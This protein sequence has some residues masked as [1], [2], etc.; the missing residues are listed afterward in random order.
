MAE[1]QYQ[2]SQAYNQNMPS[3][4]SVSPNTG[5]VNYFKIL[6]DLCGI[7]SSIGLKVTLS[8]TPGAQGS[9]G[10]TKDWGIEIPYTI[11][12]K[13]LT[14]QGKTFV[15]D[16]GWTSK[17]GYQ[18]RLKYVNNHVMLFESIFPAQPLPSRHTDPS[19]QV[20]TYCWRFGAIDG[21]I[22]YFGK[23]LEHVDI[24]GNS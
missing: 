24:Y 21:A 6:I 13:S 12:G 2:G 8:Y 11:P 17:S 20:R 15:F 16:R 4:E 19:D 5:S 1:T 3:E 18:S 7:N 23:L 22:D 9:F 10:A 14:A